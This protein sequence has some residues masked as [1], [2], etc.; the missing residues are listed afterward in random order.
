[1]H[2]IIKIYTTIYIFLLLY[3]R[4][5]LEDQYFVTKQS[6]RKIPELRFKMV[7]LKVGAR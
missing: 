2:K 1:M 3:M 7:I 4:V 5:S 6:C